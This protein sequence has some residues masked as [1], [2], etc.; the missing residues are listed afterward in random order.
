MTGEHVGT[1]ST[2]YAFGPFFIGP[3]PQRQQQVQKRQSTGRTVLRLAMENNGGVPRIV[4]VAGNDLDDAIR[5][6]KR[7]EWS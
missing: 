2:G 5:E 6:L 1:G 7:R 3:R 4:E